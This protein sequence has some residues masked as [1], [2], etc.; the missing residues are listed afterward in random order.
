[1]PHGFH[2]PHSTSPATRQAPWAL[3]AIALALL[4]L[5]APAHAQSGRD[6]DTPLDARTRAAVV[7]SL[8]SQVE[9]IYIFADKGAE[10]ARHL[11][12]RAAQK[13][14]DRITSTSEF[15]DSLTATMQAITHDLH[16]RVHYRLDPYP[17]VE[18]EQSPEEARRT[19]E[20]ERVRNFGFEQVR[21]LPGN[22]G[23]L[24]LRQFSGSPEA[25]DVAVTAMN[26][27]GRCDALIFDLRRN[28]GGD[29]G[30]IQTL[31]SYLV[32]PGV[33]LHFN[34]FERRNG[35]PL[36]QWHTSTYVPG[37]RFAGKPVFVLTSP[38]TGSAAEEFAYDVQTHRLGQCVG[39]VTVGAANPGGLHRLSEHLAAFI[40]DGRAVNPITK[41]NWEGVGVQPE[42]AVPPAE[43]LREAHVRAVKALQEHPRDEAHRAFLDRALAAAQQT[44]VDKPEEF[45]RRGPGR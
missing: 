25:H 30:M 44:P 15:A 23:Y 20:F 37:A 40:A 18:L 35:G 39:G 7:D 21:R 28:G 34:D 10:L 9:R 4:L 24:D 16:M 43:A 11:R 1:M 22:V 33:E 12:K 14:F 41:T 36:R 29:P 6:A 45:A 19:A 32:E 31:L 17:A 26:F 27:L 42:I 5:P 8:A 3:A 2:A 13:A 38:F